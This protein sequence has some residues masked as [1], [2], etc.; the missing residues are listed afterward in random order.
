MVNL[1]SAFLY[2]KMNPSALVYFLKEEFQVV[3]AQEVYS[4]LTPFNVRNP[5]NNPG[6]YQSKYLMLVKALYTK[7]PFSEPDPHTIALSYTILN[8]SGYSMVI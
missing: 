7:C 3:W 4:K 5:Q 6:I 2:L 1:A 8:K